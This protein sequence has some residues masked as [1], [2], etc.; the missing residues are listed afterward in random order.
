MRKFTKLALTGITAMAIAGAVIAQ[1]NSNPAIGAR[2]SL[3]QLR[4]FNL[5]QLG[6][7]A[8]GD[9]PYDAAAATA[10]ANNLVAIEQIDQSA[11][12]P[13]GTD[14]SVDPNTRALPAIW[15]N[16][17]DVMEKANA[18][19]SA[20]TA[21]QAAAGT[22]LASLQTA[23]GPVGAACTACHKAYRAPNN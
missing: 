5:G 23:M 6:A 15:T 13:A 12:W 22:D 1:Q 16:F 18:V 11:M 14:N 9:V 3:M 10:A 20:V 19:T 8:K 21:M 2:K 17:P 7:M 4:G